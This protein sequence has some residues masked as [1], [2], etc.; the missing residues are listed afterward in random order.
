LSCIA[1]LCCAD[2]GFHRRTDRQNRLVKDLKV[3]IV[4]IDRELNDELCDAA[5]I[6][7]R[8]DRNGA[9]RARRWLD[10]KYGDVSGLTDVGRVLGVRAGVCHIEPIAPAVLIRGWLD[11]LSGL[12]RLAVV[13]RPEE[14]EPFAHRAARRI[15]GLCAHAHAI[16]AG[17]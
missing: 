4:R 8:D 9:C 11:P 7:G 17:L 14:R 16:E 13:R 6:A 10:R 1:C 3:D 15:G 2:G 5:L 12:S